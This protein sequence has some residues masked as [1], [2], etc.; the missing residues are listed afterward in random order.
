M[1]VLRQYSRVALWLLQVV[2]AWL[3]SAALFQFAP[4]GY[5]T[6][7]LTAL[8]FPPPHLNF[9]SKRIFPPPLKLQ[10]FKCRYYKLPTICSLA[11]DPNLWEE[12]CASCGI[13]CIMQR[14]SAMSKIY[15]YFFAHHCPINIQI[16]RLSVC[17]CLGYSIQK[18]LYFP[19]FVLT[20]AW[21][22]QRF[23][24]LV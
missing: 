22:V 9:S 19:V 13:L 14:Y 17:I 8:F 7:L 10:V 6:L 20:S 23:S 2:R 24:V 3:T 15:S 16:S 5:L 12:P 18:L 4:S 11:L 21:E 1:I